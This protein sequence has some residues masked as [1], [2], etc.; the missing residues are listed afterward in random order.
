[1]RMMQNVVIDNNPHYVL[2][3]F[4]VMA[5][6]GT[7]YKKQRNSH[8]GR[9]VIMEHITLY[10]Q[11]RERVGET[12]P[13]RAK[14]LV[15]SGRATWLE[16][17]VTLQLTTDTHPP[18][19]I[20]EEIIMSDE[21]ICL[22]NGSPKNETSPTDC[23]GDNELLMY[24]ARKNVREKRN[25]VRHFAAFVAVSLV[26][27]I[28]FEV[29]ATGSH[30]LAR[31]ANWHYDKINEE[32]NAMTSSPDYQENQ[33]YQL[34]DMREFYRNVMNLVNP[35][36]VFILGVMVTWGGWILTRSA[37]LVVDKIRVR[38]TKK[39]KPDPVAL[40]YMRLKN[41]VSDGMAVTEH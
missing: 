34:S 31:M 3:L 32:M 38:S 33:I 12:Y 36:W 41:M 5:G 1:M 21:D 6:A 4:G 22:T 30:Q 20:K 8:T 26:L 23:A 9:S 29:N 27:L 16:E 7:H 40:E 17:N 35:I 25:L 14:Q 10:N 28:L 39:P 15:R 2:K 18:A 37:I 11:Q 13:R 24:L 19:T